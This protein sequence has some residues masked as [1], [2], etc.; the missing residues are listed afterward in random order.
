MHLIELWTD[1]HHL[2]MCLTS[3]WHIVHV[4]LVDN[5]AERKWLIVLGNREFTSRC[6]GLNLS[7]SLTLMEVATLPSSPAM[8]NL[9]SSTAV[10]VKSNSHTQFGLLLTWLPSSNGQAYQTFPASQRL[11]FSEG[12]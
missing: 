7:V 9:G 4:G 8:V 11:P 2:E 1:N 6:S 10:F 5:L 12:W 3:L